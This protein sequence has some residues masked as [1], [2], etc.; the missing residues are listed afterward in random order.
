[1]NNLGEMLS[2]P[3]MYRDI[4][5]TF[6]AFEMPL[7]VY[8]MSYGCGYYGGS[9]LKPTL[10]HDKFESVQKL[11]EKQS[12]DVKKILGGIGGALLAICALAIFKGKAGKAAQTVS[13]TIPGP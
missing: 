10:T 11:K 9:S 2:T 3:P 6:R 8:G 7:P 1:M 12:K 5:S 4:G 13:Q